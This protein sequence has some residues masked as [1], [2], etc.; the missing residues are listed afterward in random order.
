MTTQDLILN[1]ALGTLTGLVSGSISGYFVSAYFRNKDEELSWKKSLSDDKQSMSTYI[2]QV[3]WEF[4]QLMAGD[5]R[6][7]K[8]LQKLLILA[9]KFHSFKKIE[10][11]KTEHRGYTK[12]AYALFLEIHDYLKFD[13]PQGS[14]EI[15]KL[16]YMQFRSRLIKVQFN[17]LMIN[18]ERENNGANASDEAV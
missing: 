11:I 9:P 5:G 3:L 2:T 10:K 15:H 13:V 16:K 12:E 14:Y 7:T 8:D 17:I 6:Q 1:L 18:V 4:D